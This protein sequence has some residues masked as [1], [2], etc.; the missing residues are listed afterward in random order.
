MIRVRPCRAV[1]ALMLFPTS[2][3]AGENWPQFRG[4]TGQGHSDAR[5]LPAE[6]SESQGVA[7]QTSIP[8]QGH[9]SPVIWGDQIW[10]TTATEEGRSLR[11]VCVDKNSGKL[12]HDVELFRVAAL[13]P[14]NE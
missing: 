7:W 4:P 10:M 13:E 11:A 9:S 3:F 8:G 5:D 6:W 12:V 14:K 1:L 2:L